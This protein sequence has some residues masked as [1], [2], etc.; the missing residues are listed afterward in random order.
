MKGFAI[1]LIAFVLAACDRTSGGKSGGSPAPRA[2][3][4]NPSPYVAPPQWGELR[5]QL[6][7]TCQ[8]VVLN[9]SAARLQ[10]F[11]A[12]LDGKVKIHD[13]AGPEA[14]IFQCARVL[15]EAWSKEF[16]G[17]GWDPALNEFLLLMVDPISCK[18]QPNSHKQLEN[19]FKNSGE[20]KNEIKK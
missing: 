16:G 11:F 15:G 17:D 12:A 14:S 4:P 7:A 5:C 8:D 1:V 18:S 19:Y 2:P 20:Y 9:Q 3:Q 10:Q 6:N 13:E